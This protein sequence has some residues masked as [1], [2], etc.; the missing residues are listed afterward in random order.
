MVMNIK[1][2]AGTILI[3]AGIGSIALLNGCKTA[4]AE[5][6]VFIPKEYVKLMKHNP[7]GAFD[8]GWGDKQA[9]RQYNKIK[10]D[11]LVSPVQLKESGWQKTNVRN[12]VSSKKKDMRD[13]VNDTAKA[14]QKAF[15]KSKYFQLTDKKGP[16]TLELQFAIVQ[17]TPNKP[18]LGAISTLTNVTPIGLLLAPAKLALRSKTGAG[19]VIVMESILRDSETGKVIAVFTSRGTARVAWINTKNFTAYGNIRQIVEQWTK[20][21]ATALD[22]I[23]AGQPI[24]IKKMSR[25]ELFN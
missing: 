10:I 9:V 23:K 15:A 5:K 6:Q 2:I 24:K 3:A 11:I 22:Q 13:L 21:I 7:N 4:P 14:F 8:K 20:D 18:V 19:G 17:A 12:V 1:N 16:H 25:F